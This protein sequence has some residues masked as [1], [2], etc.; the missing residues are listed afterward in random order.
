MNSLSRVCRALCLGLLLTSLP[1]A[2]WGA[3]VVACHCFQDRQFDPARPAAADPYLLAT[4]QNRL[5]ATAFAVPRQEIVR[6]KMSGAAGDRLWIGLWLARAGGRP[7]GEGLTVSGPWVEAAARFGADPERLGTT[8]VA[9][10]T[11]GADDAALAA[12]VVEEILAGWFGAERSDIRALRAGGADGRE[13]VAA[14]LL[15]GATGQG[16]LAE[17]LRQARHDG[18]WGVRMNQAGLTLEQLDAWM[19]GRLAASRPR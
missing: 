14:A 10:M 9:R 5:I 6:R 19:Q 15:A 8:F 11:E 18:S 4:L 12:A 13:L 17:V 16:S 2:A 7:P 3:S 1:F